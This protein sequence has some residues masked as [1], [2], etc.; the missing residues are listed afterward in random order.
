MTE[1]KNFAARMGRWSAKNRKKAIVGW[2]AFVVLS[3]VIGGALGVKAPE[4]ENTYVGD[5]GKAHALVDQHFPTENTES[6]LIKGSDAGAVRAATDDT[7]A[8]VSK[9][10]GVY[11]VESPY[12]KGNEGQI[13]ADGAVLVHFKLR[14]DETAAETSVEPVLAAVERVQASHR[15]VF[16]G[17]F[18]SASANKALSKAFED[19]FK[20]AE[21]CLCRSRW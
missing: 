5:S 19:D 11:D 3:L 18:G 20:K 14:G 10:Q 21:R 7:I 12:A 9:Q 13:A 1:T 8:A 6:V 2:I 17:E 15:G 16:V 4:D